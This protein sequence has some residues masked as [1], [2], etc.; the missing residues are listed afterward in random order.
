MNT[1]LH[2]MYYLVSRLRYFREYHPESSGN[3]LELCFA[4]NE[5]Y[6]NRNKYK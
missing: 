5:L 3:I 6:K 2:M 1:E 4:I